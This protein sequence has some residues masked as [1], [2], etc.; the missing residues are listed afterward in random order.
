MRNWRAED[1]SF[2]T[3]A[4]TIGE[5]ELEQSALGKGAI[6][7]KFHYVKVR[8]TFRHEILTKK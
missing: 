6:L 7:V 1:A 8:K 4:L 3:I 5:H 2:T